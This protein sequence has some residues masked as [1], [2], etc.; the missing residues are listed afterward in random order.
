MRVIDSTMENYTQEQ[1]GLCTTN[2]KTDLTFNTSPVFETNMTLNVFKMTD[3]TCAARPIEGR[4]F[5]DS[6]CNTLLATPLYLL[7][8]L[9][10]QQG[11]LFSQKAER[12]L[13]GV[14]KECAL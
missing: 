11:K 14:D 3:D 12:S 7:L 10:G 5:V 8:Q 4:P 1:G 13:G 6:L 2:Y 9:P